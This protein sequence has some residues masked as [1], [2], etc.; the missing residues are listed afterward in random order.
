[1]DFPLSKLHSYHYLKLLWHNLPKCVLTYYLV[2]SHE[3][4]YWPLP[5]SLWDTPVKIVDTTTSGE[6][7]PIRESKT[8]FES[9]SKITSFIPASHA[10]VTPYSTAFASIS[11]GPNGWWTILLSVTTQGK[12][13]VTSALYL[14]RTS[15]YWG[16]L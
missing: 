6:R 4:L 15:H 13:L 2:I 9:P 14:K 8:I 16:S 12:A 3:K 10:K 1:M 7:N 5:W 11:K